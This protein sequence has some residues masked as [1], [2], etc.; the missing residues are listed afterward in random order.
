MCV[1]A[2]V[3]TA[4]PSAAARCLTV[5]WMEPVLGTVL[6]VNVLA[7]VFLTVLYARAGT[8]VMSDRLARQV[9]LT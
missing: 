7:D 5:R 3:A 9:W 8:G 2:E 4:R 6:M 1:Q